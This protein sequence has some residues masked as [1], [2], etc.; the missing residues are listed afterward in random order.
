MA[1]TIAEEV[2]QTSQKRPVYMDYQAMTPTDPRVLEAMLPWFTEQFGNPHSRSHSVGWQ[3]EE[4]VEGARRQVA[5][6]IGADPRE[7][8][9]TSGATEAGNLA[10]KG[11]AYYHRGRKDHIVTCV[12]EHKCIVETVAQLEREGFSATVVPVGTSGRVYPQAIADA[13]TP[14]TLMVSVMAANHEIGVLQPLSEI[15]RICRERDV[16]FHTDAAQA[17]G[18]IPID[19][20]SMA[21]DLVSLSGHKVYA[22]MGI[23][24]LYVRR[25]PRVRI[26]PL[27]SGGGQE[28][29]MRSGTLPTPLCVG[30]GAA[31]EI[32]AREM[33]DEAERL[34]GLRDRFLS[35]VQLI[36][37]DVRINGDMEHRLPGNL[38]LSFVGVDGEGLMARLSDIALS[39]GSAC[40]SASL[41][42]SYVLHAIGV[43]DE[44]A[45]NSIRFGFGRFTTD[46]E[47]DFAVRRIAE[48]ISGISSCRS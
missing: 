29:G 41:E 42:P 2:S 14:R 37:P 7:I 8:V 22:P 11:A 45:H 18:K 15:G 6:L 3:A 5:S 23:G 35:A 28:R 47:V 44:L 31:A 19:V 43:E 13:I 4:A 34:R 32:A 48:E 9:F 26:A 17:F 24:A 46:E 36:A 27:F 40:T 1:A 16:L 10:L 38:N 25:R 20:G 12:T 33:D 30:F 21:L 39:S